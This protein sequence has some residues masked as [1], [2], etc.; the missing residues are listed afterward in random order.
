[1]MSKP[2]MVGFLTILLLGLG[3]ASALAF[4]SGDS[5]RVDVSAIMKELTTNQVPIERFLGSHRLLIVGAPGMESGAVKKL[6]EEQFGVLSPLS[7]EAEDRRLLVLNDTTRQADANLDATVGATLLRRITLSGS[8]EKA[9]EVVMVDLRSRADIRPKIGGGWQV[10]LVG[11]DG[12]VKQ[13]WNRIVTEEDVF[14]LI[15]TMPMRQREMKARSG[16]G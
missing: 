1:M 16:G 15:D 10:I 5:T 14:G 7:A 9:A 13:R 4:R 12:G 11:L 2:L 3:L 6:L 8:E